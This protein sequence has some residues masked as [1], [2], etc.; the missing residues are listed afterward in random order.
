MTIPG[1]DTLKCYW[2]LNQ[3]III[4]LGVQSVSFSTTKVIYITQREQKEDWTGT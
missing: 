3:S 1:C 4:I 2:I